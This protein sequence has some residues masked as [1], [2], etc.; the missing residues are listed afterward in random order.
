MPYALLFDYVSISG[1]V[2]QIALVWPWWYF[3]LK[4]IGK[5]KI[6]NHYT[7]RNK[8]LKNFIKNSSNKNDHISELERL[9]SLKDK[10]IITENEFETKK[11]EL[12]DR[13]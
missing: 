6:G 4:I 11:K 8:M 5:I 12:L 7:E 13:I 2:L 10:G 1:V 3:T 9:S